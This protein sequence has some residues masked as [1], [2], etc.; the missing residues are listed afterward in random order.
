[1]RFSRMAELSRRT[2]DMD[3]AQLLNTNIHTQVSRIHTR[4]SDVHPIVSRCGCVVEVR[5]V[6]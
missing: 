6:G 5:G 3:I 1:M 2:I 4:L